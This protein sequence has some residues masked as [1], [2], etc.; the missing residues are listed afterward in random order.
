[1]K[2]PL[3]AVIQLLHD[4]GQGALATHSQCMPG[5][6]FAS[7][8]PFALDEAHCPVFLISG[9]AEHTRNVRADGRA[10]LV[11]Q[12]SEHTEPE[13][14]ARLTLIGD[15]TPLGEDP[16]F[17]RRYLRFQPGGDRYLNLGDFG[18]FRFRPRRLRLVAGFGQMGWIGEEE[19]AQL[20]ILPYEAENALLEQIPE[21]H[22]AIGI[23]CFGVDHL[24]EGRR[25]RHS[26]PRA[27]PPEQ[28]PATLESLG[29][30]GE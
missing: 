12:P 2:I 8:L 1:M 4:N 10:S 15:V 11:V 21:R 20:P 7:V 6:P 17:T 27:V 25:W 13:A 18:F 3:E 26:F 9:L 16:L 30:L 23:D 19:W 22:A 14:S 28:L 29:L 5:Y 24:Q